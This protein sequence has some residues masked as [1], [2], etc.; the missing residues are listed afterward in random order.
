MPHLA[1]ETL[2]RAEQHALLQASASHPRDHFIFSLALGTGL[3]LAEIVGL[4][5][6][7]V[8]FPDGTPP[9]FGLPAD[10]LL[11]NSSATIYRDAHGHPT[12]IGGVEPKIWLKLGDTV[13][14]R[15]RERRKN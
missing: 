3:R 11:I 10:S 12:K 8:Y 13:I 9:L 6:G 7:D 4:N 1:P 5:V 14:L 15:L 2:T